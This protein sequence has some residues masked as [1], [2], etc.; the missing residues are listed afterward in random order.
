MMMSLLV[1]RTSRSKQTQANKLAA[2]SDEKLTDTSPRELTQ[3]AGL[4]E[5][6][7]DFA[8]EC[9]GVMVIGALANIY[10]IPNIFMF[11][12]FALTTNLSRSDVLYYGLMAWGVEGAMLMSRSIGTHMYIRDSHNGLREEVSRY[13]V[14][15]MLPQL[16]T[17]CLPA[18]ATYQHYMYDMEAF[19][20]VLLLTITA[21]MYE[22][23]Y[24]GHPHQTGCRERLD[25]IYGHSFLIETVKRYFSGKIIRMAPLDPK[26]QYVLGFHPH[27]IT[28]TSVMWLQFSAEWRRLF[29]NFYAHILTASIMHALPLARDILQFLGS[30]EVTRQAFTYTLQHNESVLLVPGGQAEMLEQRSGQKEVRVYT[31]H[32][33]FIR[34]AIEHGVPLVP[35]LSFNEGEMLDNIQA[36]MLQR[37]FVIK[38]AFPFPFFPY[39]R[40]LLPIPRKVQIPI[41]V[42][43]PLEVPHMKK[44]SHEDIDKVHARYFDELRDMFA[45]YKDEAGCGD[46][47]L[48]YV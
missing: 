28:P 30:R 12:L 1:F 9:L 20:P 18:I 5:R 11:A 46:Y 3:T 38:L 23:T 31:H 48:I 17:T 21:Y 14:K 13:H 34:L 35:V 25:W 4:Y 39:G 24:R 10:F 2:E 44:P 32:K 40:A 43:A 19:V 33:G 22:F 26:K 8:D 6:L 36:P 41:V 42:G 16:V 29:P 7:H 27:G 45:K 37:W 15:Y 47:K